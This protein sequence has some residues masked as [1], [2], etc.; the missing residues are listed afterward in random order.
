M[1]SELASPTRSSKRLR[2]AKAAEEVKWYRIKMRDM[3]NAKKIV[4]PL[5]TSINKWQ[6]DRIQYIVRLCWDKYHRKPIHT[7]LAE[8]RRFVRYEV[9]LLT[10]P[11]GHS[12]MTLQTAHLFPID[13]EFKE[14]VVIM[15]RL[16]ECV[17]V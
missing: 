6:N 12:K 5:G 16:Q 4:R 1:R 13:K 8:I 9:Q 17:C 15:E 11:D 10:D 7:E 2:I 14:L 3:E